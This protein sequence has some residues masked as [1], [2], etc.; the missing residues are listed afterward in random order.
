MTRSNKAMEQNCR[1]PLGYGQFPQAP[2]RSS[3][4]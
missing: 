1:N 2:R 3:L 4:K